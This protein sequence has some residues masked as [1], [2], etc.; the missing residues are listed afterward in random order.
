M[1]IER[2]SLALI[3]TKQTFFLPHDDRTSSQKYI[4]FPCVYR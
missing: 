2:E 4:I 3:G 1:Y